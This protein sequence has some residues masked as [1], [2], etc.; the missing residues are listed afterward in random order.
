[1]RELQ[2]IVQHLHVTAERLTDFEQKPAEVVTI[3]V[4]IVPANATVQQIGVGAG[5]SPKDEVA[6]IFRDAT[7]NEVG[8]TMINRR[9]RAPQVR[10]GGHIYGATKET[11]EGW[12]YTQ[13]AGR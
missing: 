1:M 11:H 12:V 5:P 6:L 9:K 13:T 7:G 4:P 8:R 10:W 3:E 2:E